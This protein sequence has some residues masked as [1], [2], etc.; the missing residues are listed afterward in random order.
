VAASAACSPTWLR[1]SQGTTEPRDGWR[2]AIAGQHPRGGKPP[3]GR[4]WCEDA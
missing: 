4:S 3:Q 1:R 2:G